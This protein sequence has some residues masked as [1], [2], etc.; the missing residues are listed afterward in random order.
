VQPGQNEQFVFVVKGDQTV[1]YRPVTV[2]R[3]MDGQAVISKGLIAGETV[4]TDGHLR[5]APG[6]RVVIKAGLGTRDS[7]LGTLKANPQ[8]QS[9]TPEPRTPNPEPRK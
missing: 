5:L 3:T 7:E 4:V 6:A 2:S 1:E 8:S 9:A